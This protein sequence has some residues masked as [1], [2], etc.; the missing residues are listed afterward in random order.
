MT[1]EEINDYLEK[2]A[3]EKAERDDLAK[4]ISVPAKIPSPSAGKQAG[5][6]TRSR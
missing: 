3:K 2:T 4:N 1:P 6:Y 5:A